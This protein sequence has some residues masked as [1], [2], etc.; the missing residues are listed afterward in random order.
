MSPN[1]HSLWPISHSEGVSPPRIAVDATSHLRP[2]TRFATN[3]GKERPRSHV[4]GGQHRW[5]TRQSKLSGLPSTY[6]SPHCLNATLFANNSLAR[7]LITSD[8]SAPR[9]SIEKQDLHV[10]R[11]FYL[12][13]LIFQN[14]SSHRVEIALGCPSTCGRERLETI[15]SRIKSERRI[16]YEA[17]AQGERDNQFRKSSAK[18]CE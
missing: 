18:S 11:N 16:L 14:E 2:Y 5:A 13:R 10:R 4:R 6:R 3:R 1:V 17:E 9:K 12:R 15:V 7:K 8:T